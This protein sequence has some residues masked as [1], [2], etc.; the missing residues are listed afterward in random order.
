VALS[1]VVRSAPV[2]TG[3]TGTLVAWLVWMTLAH[4]GASGSP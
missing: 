4:R 2:M 1:L 3:V